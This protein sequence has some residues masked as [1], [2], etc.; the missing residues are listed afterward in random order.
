M[1][2]AERN[3]SVLALCLVAC[4]TSPQEL[5]VKG[6]TRGPHGSRGVFACPPDVLLITIDTLR[7]DHLPTYG[8]SGV[9]TPHLS[10][11]A[12]QSVVFDKAAA[13]TPITLP[14][15][16]SILAG[17]YPPQHGVRN[18]GSFHAKS[19][20]VTMPE[21]LR[22]AGY[23]T[24]AF[25]SAFV[26][27]SRF[28]LAQGF[29]VYDDDL[30]D[31][32][33]RLSKFGVKDRRAQSTID[34]VLSWIDAEN[35][36]GSS[37]FFV[38]THLYDP[39]FPYEPPEPFKSQ[40]P[41]P[42][43]GEIAYTDQQ[44][45]RLL[46]ALKKR[47]R[48]DN[49]L[50]ILTA[51]HG[52]SLGEHGEST[53]SIFVYEATQ[54]VPMLVK[55]PW[56]RYGGRRVGGLVRHVDI[57]P[58]VID[59]LNLRAPLGQ[60]LPGTSLLSRMSG[61][62]T[63][64]VPESYA[65]AY[66]PFDQFGWSPV[67]A[68]RDDGHKFIEAPQAELYNL[69]KDPRE[70]ENLLGNVSNQGAAFR[71]K[72]QQ[73]R[74]RLI[75]VVGDAQRRMNEE[76]IEKLRALGYVGDSEPSNSEYGKDPKE[77]VHLYEAREEAHRFM[78]TGAYER[79][80]PILRR[81]RQDDPSN[82]SVEN[83]L[84]TVYAELGRW[85]EAEA[86]F[87]RVRDL[88]PKRVGSYRGLAKVYFKGLRDFAAAEREIEGAFA[89]ADHDPSLWTLRGDFFHAQGRM[90]SAA[91]AYQK[92]VDGGVQDASLYAGYASALSNLRQY[93]RALETVDEALRIDSQNGVAQF[94][95]GVIL[96]QLGKADEAGEAFRRAIR[97]Q[98]RNLLAYEN[99]SEL[100]IK[101][102]KHAEAQA[103]LEAGLRIEPQASELLNQLGSLHVQ[104]KRLA[105]GITL[106][107]RAVVASPDSAPAR[108]NLGYAYHQQRRYDD[109]FAQY[110]TLTEIYPE[111]KIGYADAWLRLARL[112]A[113]QG[114]TED[115]KRLLGRALSAGGDSIREAVDSDPY[116]ADL[117]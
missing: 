95:R 8:Y 94:N 58:T 102:D 13:H 87:R 50:V 31:G 111:D 82:P 67:Y 73:M 43:D 19:D 48:F 68:W 59:E 85:K 76:T 34:R 44:I 37:P 90:S 9:Q 33:R 55:L 25:I 115:A 98:P 7:A 63:Q 39:H 88:A 110:K 79:A 105:A 53:H 113:Q 49:T 114:R 18:N 65:E 56:G 92:A 99:L 16:T 21:V 66:L 54:W 86:A 81:L 17:L 101:A 1:R 62:E 35:S 45:G 11:L 22:Q 89:L 23:S 78:E 12:A 14:S 36:H 51:D 52:E 93:A 40:Y 109:A 64:P 71:E 24:A 6:C 70:H 15:H 46:D 30:V 3:S 100:L 112:R 61:L 80:I 5:D 103:A 42:Y 116:L 20:L 107:E 10:T 28:G 75:P 69:E 27:D 108:T 29:D 84:A 2:R 72:L 41:R 91:A 83:D 74:A 57:L 97:L 47:G 106:L 4:S 104:E 96:V 77:M 38:W 26:L 117:L 60:S 32:R